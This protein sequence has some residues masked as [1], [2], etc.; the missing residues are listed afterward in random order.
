MCGFWRL[1]PGFFLKG[2]E[3]TRDA[4]RLAD[5]RST[6]VLRVFFFFLLYHLLCW[7][8]KRGI[9]SA[10]EKQIKRR[11]N[12]QLWS[13]VCACKRLKVR[14]DIDVLWKLATRVCGGAPRAE[15]E[16]LW[17]K[18]KPTVQQMS[19]AALHCRS[20]KTC[21]WGSCGHIV[22]L[23]GGGTALNESRGC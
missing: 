15:E 13:L 5:W 16:P 2:P 20:S 10:C 14:T 11:V 17:K 18:K 6:L 12:R 1:Q 9:T 19:P 7:G 21:H 3:T 23:S 8:L 4:G 22:T